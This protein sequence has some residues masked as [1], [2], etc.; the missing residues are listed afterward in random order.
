[1][2]EIETRVHGHSRFGGGAVTF[3]DESMQLVLG[4]G[5]RAAVQG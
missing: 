4:A 1:M 5:F 2:A 3:P